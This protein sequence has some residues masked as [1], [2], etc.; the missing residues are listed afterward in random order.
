MPVVLAQVAVFIRVEKQPKAVTR[1]LT[2]FPAIPKIPTK[3]LGFF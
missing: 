3:L 1:F 2:R